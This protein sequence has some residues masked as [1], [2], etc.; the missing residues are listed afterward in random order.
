MLSLEK[1]KA[2]MKNTPHVPLL[3]FSFALILFSFY[4]KNQTKCSRATTHQRKQRSSWY[5][6]VALT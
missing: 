2:S 1:P 3:S 6:F 4:L 5:G